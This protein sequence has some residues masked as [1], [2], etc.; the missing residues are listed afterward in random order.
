MRGA[1]LPGHSDHPGVL[2]PPSRLEPPMD[3]NRSRTGVLVGLAA[4]AGAFG[5]AATM[6]AATA[7]TARADDFTDIISALDAD[8]AAGQ[9]AFTSALTDFNSSEFAAGLAALFDGVD[10]GGLAAP[11]DFLVG[12][13]NAL[14]NESDGHSAPYDF[15]LPTDFSDAVTQAQTFLTDGLNYLYYDPDF[16]SVS[17]YGTSLYYDLIGV[18]YSI[19][20]PLEELLLGAAVS[21]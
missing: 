18:D 1:C 10:D 21:F 5:V 13:V 15:A 20:L 6:S 16:A 2:R 3:S 4:A 12:T 7:P 14:T 9:T 17:D 11:N 19:V 8:Y